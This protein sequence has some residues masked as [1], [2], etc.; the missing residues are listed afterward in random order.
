MKKYIS[1]SVDFQAYYSGAT[2]FEEVFLPLELWDEIKEDFRDYVYLGEMDGKHSDSQSDIDIKEVTEDELKNRIFPK[3]YDG[4]CLFEHVC[5]Y[6]D[7]DK[8]DDDYLLNIQ[9]EVEALSEVEEMTIKFNKN[10]KQLILNKL[11]GFIR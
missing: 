4:E 5:E 10:D 6:I 1:L 2:Y 11:E 7:W 8:N 3:Y 9:S